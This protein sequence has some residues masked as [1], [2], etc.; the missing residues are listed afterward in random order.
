MFLLIS[1]PLSSSFRTRSHSLH[2]LVARATAALRNR[3]LDVLLRHLNRAALAM[4]TVLRVDHKLLLPRRLALVVF[5]DL[6]GAKVLLWSCLFFDRDGVRN[7]RELGFD[8]QVCRLVVVVVC[9]APLQVGQ[10]IKRKHAWSLLFVCANGK[11]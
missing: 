1:L 8:S 7:V 11:E 4:H 10:N 5:V 9:T 6:C 3:P 2:N